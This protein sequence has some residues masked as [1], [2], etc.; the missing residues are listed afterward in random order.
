MK[1]AYKI[2]VEKCEAQRPLDI[3][4]D[5]TIILQWIL[6]QIEYIRLSCLKIVMSESGTEPLVATKGELVE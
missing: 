4:L 1:N 5:E 6:Q 2:Q 3:R